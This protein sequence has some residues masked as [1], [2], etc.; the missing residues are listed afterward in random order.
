MLLAPNVRILQTL[1][2]V[3]AL[4]AAGAWD[5]PVP[6]VCDGASKATL[7]V[8]YTRGGAAGSFRYLIE[9]SPWSFDQ[10]VVTVGNWFPL[11]I[12][13]VAIF[14]AGADVAVGIQRQAGDLYTAVGAALETFSFDLDLGA[15][16]QR[17]RISC[18]EVGNVAA[19]GTVHAVVYLRG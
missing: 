16:A 17:M 18:Q 12:R 6:I 14:A 11:S 1:K 10:A 15:G 4:P 19:P 7:F 9:V 2:A 13:D 8:S 3:A 5:V